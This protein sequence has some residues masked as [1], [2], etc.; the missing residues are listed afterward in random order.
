MPKKSTVFRQKKLLKK[1]DKRGVKGTVSITSHSGPEDK[2][3]KVKYLLGLTKGFTVGKGAKKRHIEV[4]YS[5]SES[6]D[7]KLLGLLSKEK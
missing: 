1:F 6:E 2:K 7:K 3:G 4:T 5:S